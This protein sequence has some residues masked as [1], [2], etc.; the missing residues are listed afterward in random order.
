MFTTATML[1]PMNSQKVDQG[2]S[3]FLDYLCIN[4][5]DF[6]EIR[7]INFADPVGIKHR[8]HR[9]NQLLSVP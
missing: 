1:V 4:L 7:C 8:K 6:I 3:Q 5:A 9:G 2:V